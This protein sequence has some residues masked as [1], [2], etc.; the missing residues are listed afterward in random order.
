MNARILSMNW[1]DSSMANQGF[2]PIDF[3]SSKTQYS[4]SINLKTKKILSGGIDKFDPQLV[5]FYSCTIRESTD[6]V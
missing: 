5:N 4:V 6:T 3:K 2:M 1:M